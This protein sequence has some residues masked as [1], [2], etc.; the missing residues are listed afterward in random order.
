MMSEIAR[1]VPQG[2]HGR[3]REKEGWAGGDR[4]RS[5]LGELVSREH[6]QETGLS[7]G[8]ISGNHKLLAN[9]THHCSQGASS[10]GP[11]FNKRRQ[12]KKKK[13]KKERNSA[14]K[15]MTQSRTRPSLI[16]LPCQKWR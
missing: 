15:T 7:A 12:K 2:C 8:T 9:F 11:K 10:E 5:N 6:N 4:E 16:L 14:S 1:D 3:E 13:K